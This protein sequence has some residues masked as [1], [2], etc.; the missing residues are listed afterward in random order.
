MAVEAVAVTVTGD[1]HVADFAA[2]AATVVVVLVSKVQK[3]RIG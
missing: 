2:A 3:T 1:F